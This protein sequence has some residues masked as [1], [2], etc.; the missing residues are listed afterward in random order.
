[1]SRECC[2]PSTKAEEP[3][4][5]SNSF[6]DG[7]KTS[8]KV[9]GMDCSDEVSAIKNAFNFSGIFYFYFF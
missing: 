2:S 4:K 6:K 5:L 3:Q 9:K 8:F 7:I 1:M